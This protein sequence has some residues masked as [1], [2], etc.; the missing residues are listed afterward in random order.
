NVLAAAS[1]IP[2]EANA[3]AEVTF[4]VLRQPGGVRTVDCLELQIGAASRLNGL[5]RKQVEISVITHAEVERQ[6]RRKSPVVLEIDAE[7]LRAAWQ[8]EVRIARCRRHAS[9]RSRR[10]ETLR[11]TSLQVTSG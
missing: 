7:H 8:I 1:H 4:V 6:A 2:R 3:G 11:V 5:P 9:D 10:G